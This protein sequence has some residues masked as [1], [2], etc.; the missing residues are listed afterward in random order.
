MIRDLIFFITT[1]ILENTIIYSEY[2]DSLIESSDFK[3]KW[4]L[5]SQYPQNE[6]IPIFYSLKKYYNRN[7]MEHYRRSFWSRLINKFVN[8]CAVMNNIDNFSHKLS[9]NRFDLEELKY[10]VSMEFNGTFFDFINEGNFFS[11]TIS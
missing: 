6:N 2:F 8:N 4:L 10:I 3:F 5:F 11:N 7:N 9:C 1:G